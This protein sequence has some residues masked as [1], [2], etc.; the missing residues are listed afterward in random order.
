MV[1][2]KKSIN[3][4]VRAGKHSQSLVGIHSL[5]ISIMKLKTFNYSA[6]H[7]FSLTVN[8]KKQWSS[9]APNITA[10]SHK[11]CTNCAQLYLPSGQVARKIW[12]GI[13]SH[14]ALS[15]MQMLQVARKSKHKVR[16]TQCVNYC[17]AWQIFLATCNAAVYIFDAIGLFRHHYI[18]CIHMVLWE[19][20]I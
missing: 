17:N 8:D 5:L 15:N 1:W 6:Y 10:W 18:C 14:P 20:Y 4:K 3:L 11:M 19:L 9:N 7:F 13:F 2:Q 12:A 16:S